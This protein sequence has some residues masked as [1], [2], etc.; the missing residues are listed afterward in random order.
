[1]S[2]NTE[3]IS[4]DVESIGMTL[5]KRLGRLEV[6]GVEMLEQLVGLVD[7]CEV[8]EEA[9][10]EEHG[11]REYDEIKMKQVEG[12]LKGL[13]TIFK[14]KIEEEKTKENE[15]LKT[16]LAKLEEEQ[17]DLK[18][19]FLC[20]VE[21]CQVMEAKLE[22]IEGKNVKLVEAVKD[23]EGEGIPEIFNQEYSLQ[24]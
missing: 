15:E 13:E 9:L 19:N 6:S 7:R 2:H 8:V 24:W 16:R 10:V 1:M 3:K 23:L 11:A 12:K 21:S 17:V 14:N 20:I 22:G 18:K 4:T 5:G